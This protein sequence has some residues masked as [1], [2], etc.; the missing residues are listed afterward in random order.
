MLYIYSFMNTNTFSLSQLLRLQRKA[1][2]H[3]STNYNNTRVKVLLYVYKKPAFVLQKRNTYWEQSKFYK[4]QLQI[5]HMKQVEQ[6]GN[7]FHL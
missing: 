5:Q 2:Q 1:N 4:K 7:I 6:I 3:S